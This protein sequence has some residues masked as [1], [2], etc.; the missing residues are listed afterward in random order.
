MLYDNQGNSLNHSCLQRLLLSLPSFPL[1]L[2][3]NW[4]VGGGW[5]TS[6]RTSPDIERSWWNRYCHLF[7]KYK[8]EEPW[9]DTYVAR[10][11]RLALVNNQTWAALIFFTE[12]DNCYAAFHTHSWPGWTYEK[13]EN[14]YSNIEEGYVGLRRMSTEIERNK[15]EN[16][17]EQAELNIKAS[18]FQPEPNLPWS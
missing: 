8:E 13:I 11:S 6:L 4:K 16:K 5:Y 2:E 18:H 12:A 14:M 9:H 1:F 17:H 3:G 10:W 15:L 7:H